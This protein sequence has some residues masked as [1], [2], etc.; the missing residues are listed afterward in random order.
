MLTA[1]AR[2]RC[3]AVLLVLAVAFL[4]PAQESDRP[5]L[6][7]NA[8][9]IMANGDQLYREGRYLEAALVWG[10]VADVD[11]SY[12]GSG[13][14]QVLALVQDSVQRGFSLPAVEDGLSSLR[15][16]DGADLSREWQREVARVRSGLQ[17]V[18]DQ[19]RFQT[20][21]VVLPTATA[22]PPTPT[23][24]LPTPTPIAVTATPVL[25]TATPVMP[26]QTPLLPT[27]T[28]ILPTPTALPPT[29]TPA[30]VIPTPTEVPPISEAAAPTP[31]SETVADTDAA[32]DDASVAQPTPDTQAPEVQEGEI[33]PL[34]AN[35][36]P[37]RLVERNTPRYPPAAE[38]MRVS[39]N[40][41]LRVLVGIDGK[42]EEFEITSV[43][44]RGLG[45]E[46]AIETVIPSWK[47]S[48]ATLNGVVVRVW[49]PIA[50]PFRLVD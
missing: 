16:L 28:A 5:P 12:L 18:L 1:E 27:P 41:R 19:G 38:R 47:F 6:P 32:P 37:P 30:P 22:I 23:P 45:F 29:P 35:V 14:K 24:V 46:R 15:L 4:L 17:A 44:Q 34:G 8:D 33:V 42:I 13:A 31:P 3:Q 7:E 40:V 36:V 48:P 39:G 10:E 9:Q 49:I 50:V 43:P 2:L 11:S 25:P 20:A 26:T 21:T